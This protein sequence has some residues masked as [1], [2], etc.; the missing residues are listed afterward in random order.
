MSGIYRRY[1]G[2]IQRLTDGDFRFESAADK[3]RSRR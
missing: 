3:L 1:L 2:T